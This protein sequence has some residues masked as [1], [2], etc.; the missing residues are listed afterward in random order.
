MTSEV[1]NTYFT[2]GLVIFDEIDQ[3]ENTISKLNNEINHRIQNASVEWI[4]VL[5]HPTALLKNAILKKLKLQ[6][7]EFKYFEN[8][9]NNIGLARNIILQKAKNELIYFT[10]PDIEH[11]SNC[12]KQL[13]N[14]VEV[15]KTEMHLLGFTGPVIHKSKNKSMNQMFYFLQSIAQKISFSFQ[16]QNHTFLNTVDHAPTCHLLIF[17]SKAQLIGGFSEQIQ[18]VGEDLDF[19]HRGYNAG[20]RFL[21][22]PGAQ[23]I[24][25]QNMGLKGWLIKVMYFGRA[26]IMVHKK[27]TS[28][29]L[30]IYRLV[31]MSFIFVFF[32]LF[33]LSKLFSGLFLLLLMLGFLMNNSVVYLLLTILSYS[34]GEVLEVVKPVLN[35]KKIN[36]QDT[37]SIQLTASNK[38]TK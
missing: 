20:L 30:R 36:A 7:P 9:E 6:L 38:N 13:I 19:S 4:F 29:P 16:I 37:I 3:I 11:T 34:V 17:K 35:Y 5:N 32:S 15:S 14:L 33:L 27:N 2:I 18:R 26:Q 12:L 25:H 21:F 23:V 31:P 22:A 1:N 10:D 8:T 28:M 24:H